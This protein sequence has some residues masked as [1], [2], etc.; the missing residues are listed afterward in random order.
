MN[1]V[2][3]ASGAAGNEINQEIIYFKEDTREYEFWVELR[4]YSW[5]FSSLVVP[6]MLE[7]ALD[8]LSL[9]K[10]TWNHSEISFNSFK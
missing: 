5:T 3:G 8:F 10:G 7:I 2:N 9:T 1:R 4:A 6:A